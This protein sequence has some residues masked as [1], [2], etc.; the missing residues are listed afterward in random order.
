MA[1]FSVQRPRRG[2]GKA[3]IGT[4]KSDVRVILALFSVSYIHLSSFYNTL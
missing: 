2:R 1:L 3:M 4:P